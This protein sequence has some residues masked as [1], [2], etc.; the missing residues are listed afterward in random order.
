MLRMIAMVPIIMVC[1][2]AGT[3]GMIKGIKKFCPGQFEQ[4]NSIKKEHDKFDDKDIR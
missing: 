1:A 4:F 2:L 3:V